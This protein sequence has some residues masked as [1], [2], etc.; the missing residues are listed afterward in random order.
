[1]NISGVN[2]PNF[3]QAQC[4]QVD[5][6]F[7]FPDSKRE[8]QARLPL[9]QSICN[10]CPHKSECAEFAID[11]DITDGF[12]GGLT[13]DQRE[14]ISRSRGVHF[15]RRH[16]KLH[17]ILQKKLHG[18]TVENIAESMGIDVASVERTLNR[19]KSKGIIQ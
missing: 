8:Y 2:F 19:G 14:R 1:M 6:D 11:E 12:W 16:R 3:P 5:P 4:A 17:E 18:W 9:L 7:F 10:Q 13:P 15:D